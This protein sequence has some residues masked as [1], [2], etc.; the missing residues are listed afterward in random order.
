[1]TISLS[2]S[3]YST[4]AQC[5]RKFKFRYIDRLAD[6]KSEA[7]GRGTEVHNSVEDYLA[8]KR[9]DLH[10]DIHEYYGQFMQGLRNAGCLPEVKLAI[11][12]LWEQVEWDSPDAY[13]RS[14]IDAVMPPKDGVLHAF[15]WKTGKIYPEHFNQRELYAVKLRVLYPDVEEI[16]VTGVYLDL[17]QNSPPY[18]LPSCFQEMKIELWDNRFRQV[19]RDKEYIPNPSFKCRFCNFRKDAGGPCEF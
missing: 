9:E 12:F 8:G 6:T 19:L 13:C 11:N 17:K 14:M 7:M 4:W 10:P 16:R 1:M 15:E 5:A 2:Y 18:I 3:K